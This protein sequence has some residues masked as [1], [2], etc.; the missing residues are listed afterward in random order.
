M[1]GFEAIAGVS[2]TLRSLL[3][4]QMVTGADVTIAPPDVTVTGING[5]RANL[6]LFHVSENGHLKNQEIPGRGHPGTYGHP[7][8]SLDLSYLVTAYGASADGPDADLQAQ[9]ILGDVMRVFHDNAIVADALLDPSLVGEFERIK[10]TLQPAS[11]DDLSKLWTAM[12]ET[13]FRRSVTY[14]VSVIQIESQRRRTTPRPVRRRGVYAFPLQSP[15]VDEVFR[16]PPFE[17]VRSPIAEVGDTLVIA[18]SNLAGLATR[19]RIGNVTV[20]VAAPQ[21]RRIEIPVPATVAAGTHTLQVIHDLPLEGETGQ[22]PVLHRGFASNVVPL[23]VLPSLAAIN[24]GA[25][26]AG[27]LVTVTVDPAV[28]AAQ[29]RTL[30]LDD[31]EIAGQPVAVGS[32]PSANIDF[33]L[34]TGAAALAA[35]SYLVRVRVDG[36]ESRL[37]V[38]P[39][40][41]E[42]DGPSFTV[43]P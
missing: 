3:V 15:H 17:N 8:L 22:P 26:S 31:R 36:A 20:S 38:D 16:D 32:P 10:I 41:G 25:A 29:S 13:A 19:V 33:R 2:T 14:A 39:V 4:D 40:T 23:L 18:G 30:L 9:Q 6:Y 43:T 37:T 7:P 5:E 27:D 21:A 24:P 11:M 28:A 1:S 42:Y 34:P 12:P 35:G